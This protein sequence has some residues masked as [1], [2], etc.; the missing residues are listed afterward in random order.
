MIPFCLLYINLLAIL[1]KNGFGGCFRG[2]S[3]GT[4]LPPSNTLALLREKLPTGHL[5]FPPRPLHSCYHTL[6]F[7]RCQ[8]PQDT[9]I[10]V[11]VIILTTAVLRN[12]SYTIS[13]AHLNGQLNGF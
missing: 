12:N 4:L 7:C 1:K 5:H 8:N 9:V 2:S 6:Q 11:A 13:S 3:T 10:L